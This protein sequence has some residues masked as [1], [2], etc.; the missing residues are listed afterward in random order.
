MRIWTPSCSPM[1]SE[2]QG[3]LHPLISQVG[4]GVPALAYVAP[5]TPC[6]A[7]Y[8]NWC[9]G[10]SA[11]DSRSE[12][13]HMYDR[14]SFQWES[15]QNES[16]TTQHEQAFVCRKRTIAHRY[17]L[18]LAGKSSIRHLVLQQTSKIGQCPFPKVLLPLL[19]RF[20]FR[21][22]GTALPQRVTMGHVI[23]KQ[24]N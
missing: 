21:N 4:L 2:Y 23:C 20:L 8:L 17:G 24:K 18:V 3:Q 6:P 5:S 1:T 11:P 13:H 9:Q 15:A 14:P 7:Y 12:E 22:E 10:I 19:A 16:S